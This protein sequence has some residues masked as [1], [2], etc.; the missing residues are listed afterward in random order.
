MFAPFARRKPDP[1]PPAL[2]GALVAAAREPALYAAYGV[3]DTMQGRFE[4]LTVVGW[5]FLRRAKTSP[6]LR[7]IAQEV[8]DLLFSEL[9]R[10]LRESGVG[11]LSVPKKMRSI[12]GLFYGRVEAYD[13]AFEAGDA[14]LASALRRAVF[15]DGPGDAA[16]LRDHV[17]RLEAALR[18]APDPEIAAGRLPLPVPEEAP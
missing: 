4:M 8:V 12:A 13:R 3:A 11:D 16:R 5:L 10:A 9:D 18:L 15:A 6:G 7:E 1:V 14:A 2:Y 17:R